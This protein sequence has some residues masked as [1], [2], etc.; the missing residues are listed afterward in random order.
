MSRIDELIAEHCPGGVE[1]R[2]LGDLLDY[3][4]PTAYLVSSQDYSDEFP[5]PVLTAGQ[6]FV[7]GHTDE[8]SGIYP[9]SLKSPVMIF[10]DFTTACRWVDFPFKAKSS[11]MKMLTLKRG[12]PALFRFVF[13]A[14]S[15]ID[16]VPADHARH[17][18]SKYSNF[19]IPVP[20]LEVQREIVRILDT[21]TELEAELEAEL[22]ARR[23]QFE[24][25]RD[26]LLQAADG[27]EYKSLGEVGELIRGN[28]LQK[29]DLATVG[30]P[31]IH[32]GQIHTHYG[33]WTD[34]TKSF[35]ADALAVRLRRASVGDLIIATTSENDEAVAKA[36]AW[37]GA[38]EVAVS[39]DA[40]IF[41]HGLD[42]RYVAYFFQTESFQLQKR[43]GITGTKVRRISGDALARIRIPVPPLEVQREISTALDSFDALVNDLSVGLPAELAARRKQYEY[44]RDRLLTFEEARV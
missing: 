37:V 18:I 22:Q 44:Y 1:Y 2:P 43:R 30:F 19:K 31:A 3:E 35:V 25:Y 13:Y 15:C 21:F 42:P 7:L 12:A 17:W 5:I 41:R 14:M 9:A 10:D 40:Y 4:Q 38:T 11:A 27:I 8:R 16:Y 29:S 26:S 23:Q 34:V 28:G 39:G 32:Y 24:Y 6:T 36:T 33:T 20:P